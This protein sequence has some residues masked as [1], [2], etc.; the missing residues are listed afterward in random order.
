MSNV[1]QALIMRWKAATRFARPS[2]QTSDKM[3]SLDV[4]IQGPYGWPRFEGS[5]TRLPTISGVYLMTFEYRDGFL[6]YGF[7]ITRRPLRKRFLEHT[8][9]YITGNYNILDL[10][11]AQQGIR[12]VAWKGWSW[13][14]EKRADFE[15]R[16]SEIVALAQ[17]QISATRIFVMRIGAASRLLERIEGALGR[18]FYQNENTLCDR[19][20]FLAPRWQTEEPILATIRCG[21]VLY[22]LPS[23]L[24][25]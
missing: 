2:S 16:R 5:R 22:E 3:E 17:Q 11:A 12:K 4:D 1:S 13:T 14:P 19:G 8:R 21:S 7:G 18:H 6:P 23:Q 25:I 20:M 24:E 15:A 9:S 10:E